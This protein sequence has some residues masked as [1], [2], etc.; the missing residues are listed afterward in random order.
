MPVGAKEIAHAF[1]VE[2][3]TVY[4]WTQRGLLPPAPWTV[5]GRPAWPWGA[6][7]KW[8]GETGRA[9]TNPPEDV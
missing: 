6:I 3:E 8:A 7:E 4:Q 2:V 5:S 9:I 1:G